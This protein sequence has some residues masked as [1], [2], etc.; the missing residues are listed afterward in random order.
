[1]LD[2]RGRLVGL[3][4]DR[5]F[6]NIAGDYGY[7]PAVSRNVSVDIRFLLWMLEKVEEAYPILRELGIR[8]SPPKPREGN[9]RK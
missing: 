7:M 2:G 5:V 1:V 3:N 4:F 8:P 9:D 6:E